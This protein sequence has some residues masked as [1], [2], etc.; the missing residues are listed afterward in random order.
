M[1]DVIV[2]WPRW[3]RWLF[4]AQL[5]TMVLLAI[6]LLVLQIYALQDRKALRDD[7]LEL[8]GD[9]REL[10]GRVGDSVEEVRGWWSIDRTNMQRDLEA[11][12]AEL[13]E[14]LNEGD[15][16]EGDDGPER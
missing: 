12:F 13:E 3:A 14:C 4:V 7:L 10:R 16:Q 8:R 2:S 9:V 6:A 1:P 5:L 15:C 11:R